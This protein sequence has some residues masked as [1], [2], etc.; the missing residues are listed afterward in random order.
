[1]E[2]RF[3]WL[4]PFEL[5]NELYFALKK[6]VFQFEEQFEV[7]NVNSIYFDDF[8]LNSVYQNLDGIADKQKLRLRYNKEDLISNPVLEIKKRLVF[9]LEKNYKLT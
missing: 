3:E 2:T 4:L 7:R 6:S 5:Y 9:W 8:Y 1:M